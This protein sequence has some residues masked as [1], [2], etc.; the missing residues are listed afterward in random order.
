[1]KGMLFLSRIAVTRGGADQ[2]ASPAATMRQ[3]HW[4]QLAAAARPELEGL[5]FGNREVALK[6][7][8]AQFDINPQ[9]LRRSLAALKFIENLDGGKFLKNV[10]LR[11][12]PVAAIEHVARWY[13]YDRAAALRAAQRLSAGQYT[14]AALGA[15]EKAARAVARPAPIG[16]SLLHRCRLRVGPV[17][18]AQFKALEF[19]RRTARAS[20]EPSVDF[21]FRPLGSARWTVAAIILGPYRDARL[22]EIRLG[23]W[24][25]RALGLRAIYQRVILVVPTAALK[26]ACLKW[27]RANAIREGS[28]DIQVIPP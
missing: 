12:A 5:R 14:V 24:I 8:A 26:K 18:K 10:S 19:D 25:V 6:R 1:M 17:L 4:T 21:R 11:S 23:D 13:A 22:Y 2:G 9:T 28:F 27:M 20:Q 16:R 3:A 7:I 15:A